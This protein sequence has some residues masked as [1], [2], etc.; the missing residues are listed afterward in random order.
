MKNILLIGHGGFYNR[1][2][3]AI[4]Q[5]TS[6]MLKSKFPGINLTLASFDYKN[7]RSTNKELVNS[8]IPHYSY[9]W[10]L[11]WFV[12]RIKGIVS[13]IDER[14]YWYLYPVMQAVEESDLILSIGGDNYCYNEP[15]LLLKTDSFAH[16]LNKPI[17]LWGATVD[18]KLL[19]KNTIID[20]GWFSEITCRDSFTFKDLQSNEINNNLHLVSDPAF[21][22]DSEPID[23]D[24]LFPYGDGVI[25]LNFSP[26]LKKVDNGNESKDLLSIVANICK[27]LIKKYNLGIIL[28]PHVTSP[29]PKTLQWNDDYK[30]MFPLLSMIDNDNQVKIL[31]NIYNASQTKYIISKCRFF[32]GA[33]THSTIA[34]LSS[35][36]PTISIA[37]SLKAWG[38]N[39]DIFEHNDFVVDIKDFNEKK[40]LTLV[41]ELFANEEQIRNL[42][43]VKIPE[44]KDKAYSGIEAIQKYILL[45]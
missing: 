20:L 19:S 22:L 36:V 33:R 24:N 34:S 30:F 11:P 43:Q 6:H 35:G 13:N 42:L 37:Y 28:I 18:T 44:I 3:E 9:K 38:I 15:T 12:S 2:C 29:M 26:L 5:S 32:I 23:T 41:E 16:S 14:L 45:N 10:T 1:G 17:I 8:I 27:E 21:T 7:D 39:H 4:V 40:I 25:G 31:P